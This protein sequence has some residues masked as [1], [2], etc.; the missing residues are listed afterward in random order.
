MAVSMRDLD[1]AFQGAGQ[2]AYPCVMWPSIFII[3]TFK[4]YIF[5]FLVNQVYEVMILPMV[6]DNIFQYTKFTKLGKLT[7]IS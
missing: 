3:S 2:K 4:V 7:K 1:Q 5:C 6:I